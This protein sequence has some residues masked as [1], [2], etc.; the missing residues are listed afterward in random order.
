VLRRVLNESTEQAATIA[1]CVWNCKTL[2]SVAKDSK[3]FYKGVRD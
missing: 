1:F 3:A 2:T